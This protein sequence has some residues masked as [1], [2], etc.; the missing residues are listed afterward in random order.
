MLWARTR[1]DNPSGPERWEP[2]P[3]W[4]T[5]P[6]MAIAI[7]DKI[8]ENSQG[9]LQPGEQVQA[10]IGGQTLSGWWGL[11]TSLFF[12]WNNFR[13]VLAT[14]RRVIVLHCGKW[15]MGKPRS[16][17]RELPR[18]TRIG[19]ASGLWWKSESLGEKLYVHKRFHKDVA[20]ADAAINA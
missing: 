15:R 3:R 1:A 14:D 20:L 10:V 12:F 5:V 7:R 16:I 8:I 19:P 17:V 18:N 11:L 2:V 4:G 13:A 9:F 6:G